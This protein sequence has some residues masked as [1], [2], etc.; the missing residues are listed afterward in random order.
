MTSQRY[1]E[2]A[3]EKNQ[4]PT[5]DEIKAF[6]VKLGFKLLPNG[7]Y[8]WARESDGIVVT[9]TKIL[10]FITTEEGICPIDLILSKDLSLV[11]HDGVQFGKNMPLGE[12]SKVQQFHTS[13]YRK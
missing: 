8:N 1:I 3:D 6:M 11:K 9:D 4:N 2:P 12:L 13:L 7:V 10:N 5:E